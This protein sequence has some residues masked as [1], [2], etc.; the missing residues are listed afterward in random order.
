MEI[1]NDQQWKSFYR[2]GAISVFA[3]MFVMLTEMFITALPDGTVAEHTITYLLEMYQRNWFMAMRY[4][5]LMNI[6]ATSLMIPVFFAL[7]GVHRKTN[8]VFAAFALIISLLSYVIFMADNVSFPILHLSQKYSLSNTES[9]KMIIIAAVEALFAKGASHTPG[10]FPGFFIGD[11]GGILFCIVMIIGNVFKK[12]TGI[13]GIVAF[14]FLLTFEILCSFIN[15]FSN[16]AM[17]FVMIGG[18]SALVWYVLVG[19]E[20]I[21][22]SKRNA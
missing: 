2:V 21:K 4:M 6:F 11:I 12:I 15:R 22:A 17:I 5:G 18:T 20:L 14:V 8:G 9:E 1:N 13:I 10:T 19:L 3:A 16:I 7:Y